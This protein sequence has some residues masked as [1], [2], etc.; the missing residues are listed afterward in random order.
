MTSVWDLA[1]GKP[2]NILTGDQAEDK[3]AAARAWRDMGSTTSDIVVKS[4]NNIV[5]DLV[6]TKMNTAL[7]R[8]YIAPPLQMNIATCRV[9]LPAKRLAFF[10]TSNTFLVYEVDM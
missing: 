8:V 7:A 3:R 4:D 9:S 10:T 6:S 5:A 2:L 1:S